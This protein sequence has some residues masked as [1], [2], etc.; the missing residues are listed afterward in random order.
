MWP[1]T[2]NLQIMKFH[3]VNTF[4]LVCVRTTL[5]DWHRN[6]LVG[7][8]DS[9]LVMVSPSTI[10]RRAVICNLTHVNVSLLMPLLVWWP[11]S[12]FLLC[13]KLD[14][15]VCISLWPF[16]WKIRYKVPY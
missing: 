7:S 1:T 10:L 4:T 11:L 8:C 14:L 12:I 15:L 6:G 3:N 2:H 16:K 13:L 5:Q 9:V